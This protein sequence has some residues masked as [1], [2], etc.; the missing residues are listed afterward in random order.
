VLKVELDCARI[1]AD[2]ILLLDGGLDALRLAEVHAHFAA[3]ARCAGFFGD[4]RRILVEEVFAAP[5][6]PTRAF[7]LPLTD[8]GALAARIEGA[9]LRRVGHLLYEVLKAEFLYDYGEN[10]EPADEPISD[11][12]AE[13]VRGAALVEELRDWLDGDEVGGVDLRDVARRFRPPTVDI[14]RL[15]ALI[16]GMQAVSRFD[17]ALAA[18]A[19]Y[20]VGL[21]HIKA[22]RAGDAKRVLEPLTTGADPVLGRLARITLAVV[23]GMLEGAPA[24]SVVR[25]SAC[26]EGDGFDGLIHFN[27]AQAC[28]E[29]AGG[30]LDA[31]TLEHL[32]AARGLASDLVDRQ[33]Q[34][35][36]ARALRRALRSARVGVSHA[37]GP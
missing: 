8:F 31:A 32:G 4:L 37:G 11:P 28:F 18:K 1:E 21:A 29:A 23:P 16:D 14:D 26:L 17:P 22:R 34:T 35:P 25:L 3:C 36:S 19:A 5:F 9:D 10:V 12:G 13:R 20:Y 15:G 30:I 7:S 2:S 24:E 6:G 33:L 27:L